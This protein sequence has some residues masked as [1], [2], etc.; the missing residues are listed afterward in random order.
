MNLGKH[1]HDILEYQMGYHFLKGIPKKEK[2]FAVCAL[3]YLYG[4][5]KDLD[6][7]KDTFGQN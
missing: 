3:G 4:T 5:S 6:S 7:T 1:E 2:V